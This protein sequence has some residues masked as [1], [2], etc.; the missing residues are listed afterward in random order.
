MTDQEEGYALNA[1][2]KTNAL[3]GVLLDLLKDLR[4]E[5]A[6]RKKLPPYVIF[7]DPSLEDM[8]TNYPITMDELGHISG[9]SKGKAMRYGRAFIEL[10]ADYV[11]E[12]EI[13]R[14]ADMVVKSMVNKSGQKVAI[15]QSID[16]KIPLE[17]IA[18][19]KN[20]NMDE[21]IDELDSIVSSGTKVDL[22][23]YVEDI[24]DEEVREIIFDYFME[25]ESDSV[26][27]AFAELSEEDIEMEEIKLVRIKFLSELA[28]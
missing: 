2:K 25:A 18:D 3:D 13:E 12:N 14:P 7:Q 15:I 20:M 9:V 4:K 24:V 1:E 26:E 28:N 22:N 27:E 16:K 21:L 8:A 11:E 23:Y 5:E 10:I 6:A 17:D 19:S